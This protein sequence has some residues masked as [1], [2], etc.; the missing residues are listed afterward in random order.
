M[1]FISLLLIIL[2]LLMVIRPSIVW[3]IIESWKSHD[4]TEPS[5]LYVVSARIGGVLFILAGIGGVLGYWI[6]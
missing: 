4:A 2:G 5:G 3:T 6:L 1:G